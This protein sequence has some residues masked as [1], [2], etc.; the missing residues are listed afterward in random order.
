MNSK[1]T[2]IERNILGNYLNFENLETY[3][4]EPITYQNG[5]EITPETLLVAKYEFETIFSH[6]FKEGE[7]IFIST[8][9]NLQKLDGRICDYKGDG[10]KNFYSKKW[11]RF[12]SSTTLIVKD[13]CDKNSVQI[14]NI[15]H[16]N[17]SSVKIKHLIKAIMFRDFESYRKAIGAKK[18]KF[19]VIIFYNRLNNTYVE[20]YDDRYVRIQ[21][22]DKKLKEYFQK[23]YK[24]ERPE[25]WNL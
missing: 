20:L 3:D 14:S 2:I 12:L 17:Y 21:F 16:L 19:G 23:N 15:Y 7:E 13:E 5:Y 4:I 6:I 8:I 22:G 18:V 24:M 9:D 10:I 11:L 1:L 25:D